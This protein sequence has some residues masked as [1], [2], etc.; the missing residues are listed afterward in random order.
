MRGGSG[1]RLLYPLVKI[2]MCWFGEG[3]GGG[4]KGKYMLKLEQTHLFMSNPTRQMDHV[5]ISL[6][7]VV[8]EIVIVD[9]FFLYII[10]I[11]CSISYFAN[12]R[13]NSF[14]FFKLTIQ[15]FFLVNMKVIW[16]GVE[17]EQVEWGAGAYVRA[18]SR[19]G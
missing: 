15:F 13:Y 5:Y 19:V 16:A 7:I 6:Q 12:C 1:I 11:C 14:I 3:M 17:I 10:Q 4:V 2:V 18:S 8:L 9:F